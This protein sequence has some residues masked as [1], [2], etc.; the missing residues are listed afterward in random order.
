VAEATEV[1]AIAV[2][3]TLLRVAVKYWREERATIS[4]IIS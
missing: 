3:A 2:S 1:A 4:I